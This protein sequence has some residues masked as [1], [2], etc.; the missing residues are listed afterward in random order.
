MRRML[1][2]KIFT[3]VR[4]KNCIDKGAVKNSNKAKKEFFVKQYVIAHG[5]NTHKIIFCL[6]EQTIYFS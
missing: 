6:D 5:I 2:N 4:K 3:S 1:S